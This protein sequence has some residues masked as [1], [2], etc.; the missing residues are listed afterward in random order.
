MVAQCTALWSSSVSEDLA[1]KED[2]RG[3]NCFSVSACS[4]L[5]M[6]LT[7]M[8]ES[9][10]RPETLC[11]VGEPIWGSTSSKGAKAGQ[12]NNVDIEQT[13][14]LSCFHHSIYHFRVET[15]KLREF[16]TKFS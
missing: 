7:G 6:W 16:R 5:T 4:D 9:G 1:F 12:N 14:T 13:A 10:G 2:R 11:E 15:Q 3:L 8:I